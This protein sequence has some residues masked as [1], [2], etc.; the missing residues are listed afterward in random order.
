MHSRS[1]MHSRS[2]S[3]GERSRT[4]A[5]QAAERSNRRRIRSQC[6]SSGSVKPPAALAAYHGQGPPQRRSAQH[7]SHLPRMLTYLRK[8]CL[9]RSTSIPRHTSSMTWEIHAHEPVTGTQSPIGSH[10]RASAA[11]AASHPGCLKLEE[12]VDSSQE[13]VVWRSLASRRPF[14]PRLEKSLVLCFQPLPFLRCQVCGAAALGRPRG[15][16]HRHSGHCGGRVAAICCLLSSMRART[17]RRPEWSAGP[18]ASN[19]RS[20]P[21]AASKSPLSAQISASAPA[22]SAFRS[23]GKLSSGPRC[24]SRLRAGSPR[25][26]HEGHGHIRSPT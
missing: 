15:W 1:A 16:A 24:I 4:V 11:D 19:S 25:P 2:W 12:Q 3:P 5:A 17:R 23:S 13:G 26:C 21:F 8:H 22:A 18:R 10:R 6:V 9:N 7:D 14:Q 20:H